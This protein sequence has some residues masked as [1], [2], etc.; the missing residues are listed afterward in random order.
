MVAHTLVAAI[1]P[2]LVRYRARLALGPRNRQTR[3]PAASLAWLI[4]RQDALEARLA[5]RK[6]PGQI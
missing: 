2:L 6:E 4:R 5:E 3:D 1:R